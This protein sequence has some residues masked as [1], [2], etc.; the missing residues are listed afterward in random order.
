MR[1]VT[2][3]PGDVW[4]TSSVVDAEAIDHERIIATVPVTNDHVQIRIAQ[5]V[6]FDLLTDPV[7][8]TPSPPR[9]ALGEMFEMSADEA[10]QIGTALL[11]AA[12][13]LDGV[14]SQRPGKLRNAS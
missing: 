5:R 13:R 2:H 4:A 1:E 11:E 6:D 14:K 10:R 3:E 8:T 9:I 7:T 12:T